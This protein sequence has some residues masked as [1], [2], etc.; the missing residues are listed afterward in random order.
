MHP[1][2]K[3]ATFLLLTLGI[4][5]QPLQGQTFWR[6]ES[7]GYQIQ[8]TAANLSAAKG[9]PNSSIS[10]DG[11]ATAKAKW[12][13]ISAPASAPAQDSAEYS[14]ESDYRLLSVVGPI[15]SIEEGEECD[16]GGAHPS[17]F[18]GFIAYDLSK[19]HTTKPV[20]ASL[21]DYFS[22]ETLY[23]ALI[24]DPVVKKILANK[25]PISLSELRQDLP[26]E[27][28]TNGNCDY[29]FGPDFL[30]HFAFYDHRP[31]FVSI[32]ISLSHAVETCRGQFTQVGLE[33]PVADPIL[34]E[35]LTRAKAGQSGILMKALR[36]KAG[37]KPV[38]SLSFPETR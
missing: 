9:G 17:E 25:K 6:G 14:Y 5:G 21:L 7:G 28:Y 36:Q 30:N 1:Q 2:G 13:E 20:P 8:W 38:T 29:E 32:R 11:A 19:S 23:S 3:I 37:G 26:F 27:N 34:E 35:A 15:M 33:L 4:A 12:K 24:K 31:G 16:C 22:A 10:F 18:T